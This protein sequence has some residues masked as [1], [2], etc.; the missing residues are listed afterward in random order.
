MIRE[1]VHFVDEVNLESSLGRHVLR[2]LQ[3]LAGIVHAGPRSR[4]HLDE[5]HEPA[6]VDRHACV[7][8]AAGLGDDPTGAIQGLCQDAR[9]RGLADAPGAGEQ[10]RM[11]QTL[12]AERIDQRLDDML[13][14][15]HFCKAPWPPF[16]RK[17]RVAHG[18]RQSPTEFQA[19]RRQRPANTSDLHPARLSEHGKTNV[20]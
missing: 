19:Q 8:I 6:F 9:H 20:Q 11:V 17:N 3:Q 5:V 16:S 13:L 12:R 10:V 1:H 15:N 7:A 14:A 18:Y 4:I 2:V